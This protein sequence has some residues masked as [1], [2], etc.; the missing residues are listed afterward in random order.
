MSNDKYLDLFRKI[1]AI[2]TSA[3]DVWQELSNLTKGTINQSLHETC[4]NYVFG[5]IGKSVDYLKD[6]LKTINNEGLLSGS[7]PGQG[8]K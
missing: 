7:P 2:D 1:Q 6:Y 8:Q 5:S 3:Y 4:Q